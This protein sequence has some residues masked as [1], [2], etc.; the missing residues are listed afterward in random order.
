MT[1]C[2]QCGKQAVDGDVYCDACG[3]KL[4]RN[5]AATISPSKGA[6]ALTEAPQQTTRTSQ[7][8]KS[9]VGQPVDSSIEISHQIRQQVGIHPS[10]QS[11]KTV[12]DMVFL[13]TPA[14]GAELRQGDI[15]VGVGQV[16]IVTLSEFV[17][18]VQAIDLSQRFTLDVVRDGKTLTVELN[19][20]YQPIKISPP[21]PSAPSVARPISRQKV[22]RSRDRKSAVSSVFLGA[23]LVAAGLYFGSYGVQNFAC[24]AASAFGEK[25][26]VSCAWY[27]FAYAAKDWSIGFG[28]FFFI[29]GLIVLF[30]NMSS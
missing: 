29:I 9:Q 10:A 26:P 30:A 28:A 8:R 15:L 13:N 17:A 21:P 5:D 4:R 6:S 24:N 11:N 7:P 25:Q 19:P 20:N 23:I 22:A 18:A 1:F 12:I 3:S 2:G 27:Q 16:S 14:F